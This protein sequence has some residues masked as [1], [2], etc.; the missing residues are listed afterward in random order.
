MA[1][2]LK[3]GFSAF[4]DAAPRAFS[5]CSAMTAS[6]FGPATR[7]ALASDRRPGG[8]G[9]GGR[10]LHRQERAALDL[11]APEGLKVSRLVVIGTGKAADLQAEG[12][13]QARRHRHGQVPGKRHRSNRVRRTVRRAPE[14]GAGGR[15][16]AGHAPARLCVRPLQDQAQGRRGRRAA[17]EGD[18]SRSPMR[19]RRAQGLWP[20]RGDRRRRRHGARPGQ[21]AGQ[22]ALSGG[23]RAP[24]RR[25]EESSASRS[26]SSTCGR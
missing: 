3:L 5:S 19:R 13:R 20:A 11:V 23:I 12:L 22:R 10:P 18:A 7:R 2:A 24:R 6:K 4:A 9:G 16:G 21:R 26:K 15:S 8:A 14:R 17:V 1:D 25:A